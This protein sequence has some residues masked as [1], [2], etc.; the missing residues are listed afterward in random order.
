M[1]NLLCHKHWGQFALKLW[2]M[3]QL[4]FQFR[5]RVSIRFRVRVTVLCECGWRVR[6]RVRVWAKG[7]I[8]FTARLVFPF[9][10]VHIIYELHIIYIY[11]CIGCTPG[12]SENGICLNIS[13][14]GEVLSKVIG[15]RAPANLM[16]Q[17]LALCG[18]WESSQTMTYRTP[19][20]R[21][22]QVGPKLGLDTQTLGN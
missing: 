11:I 21:K 4:G 18:V 8:M 19:S 1:Y 7:C 5:V 3:L 9:I 14:I 10:Y 17:N 16:F 15:S 20:I 12:A 22:A 13:H 6:Y 2:F